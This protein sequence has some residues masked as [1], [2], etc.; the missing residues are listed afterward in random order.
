MGQ[1]KNKLASE[2]ETTKSTPFVASDASVDPTLAS[3]F[4]SSVSGNPLLEEKHFN[5]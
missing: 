5:G 1:K 2:A 3:L 4:D